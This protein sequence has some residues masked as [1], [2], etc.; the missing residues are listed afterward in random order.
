MTIRSITIFGSI[1]ETIFFFNGNVTRNS[2][3]IYFNW[4][5]L[6][7]FIYEV[8]EHVSIFF[9]VSESKV[10]KAISEMKI[11]KNWTWNH[12]SIHRIQKLNL[13]KNQRATY[14]LCK[15]SEKS[16]A[17]QPW[18]LWFANESKCNPWNRC[19]KTWNLLFEPNFTNQ[20]TQINFSIE[21][22][23]CMKEWCVY[24]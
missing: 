3:V 1:H 6:L 2:Y 22:G 17:G 11:I 23:M 8:D 16:N 9:C 19:A 7:I 13:K 5:M 10:W 21:N 14:L 18:Q 4:I 24:V 12:N 15:K 20:S